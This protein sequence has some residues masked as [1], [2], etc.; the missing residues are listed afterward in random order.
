[1]VAEGVPVLCHSQDLLDA[2][3]AVCSCTLAFG[4]PPLDAETVRLRRYAITDLDAA[5]A[6]DRPVHVRLSAA[7]LHCELADL[8][9]RGTG[10]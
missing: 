5:L 6:S 10:R 4:P 9:L 8:A 2:A 3:R 1:M 7:A